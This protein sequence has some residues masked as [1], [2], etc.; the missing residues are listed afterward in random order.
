MVTIESAEGSVT[1]VTTG[2][3][4]DAVPGLTFSVLD[5]LDRAGPTFGARI[6]VDGALDEAREVVARHLEGLRWLSSQLPDAVIWIRAIPDGG[7]LRLTGG[8]FGEHADELAALLG[9]IVGGQHWRL[10]ASFRIGQDAHDHLQRLVERSVAPAYE[11]TIDRSPAALAV[12]FEVEG[13]ADKLAELVE[14]L[15]FAWRQEG[16]EVEALVEVE[17]SEPVVATLRTWGDWLALER[18]FRPAPSRTSTSTVVR[19]LPEL[20]SVPAIGGLTWIDEEGRIFGIEDGALCSL[21][22][23]T[24][25]E[26]ADAEVRR[27]EDGTMYFTHAG[28]CVDAGVRRRSARHA[29]R[30]A[31]RAGVGHRRRR[32]RGGRARAWRR[33]HRADRDRPATA[34]RHS[35]GRRVAMCSESSSRPGS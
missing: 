25:T 17:G 7:E 10:Y 21:S 23:R 33:P 9:P 29:R 22:E 31:A 19:E 28:R 26:R 6:V 20:A 4:A 3:L 1:I 15:R 24:E 12:G 30:A 27:R 34:S 13:S 11:P 32:A 35:R 14:L 2:E 5:G 16:S 18:R 8:T